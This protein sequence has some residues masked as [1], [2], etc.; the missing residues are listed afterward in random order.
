MG[1]L[2]GI[3]IP[4][5]VCG[6]FAYGITFAFLHKEHPGS[7]EPE[8]IKN[9]RRCAFHMAISGPIGLLVALEDTGAKHGL[10]W[11]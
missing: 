10:K 9:D 6:F 1:F 4:W 8:H 11:R 3:A 7:D 5:A 2:V